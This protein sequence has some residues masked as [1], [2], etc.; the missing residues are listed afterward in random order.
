MARG[1]RSVRS[2]GPKRLVLTGALLLAALFLARFSWHTPITDDAERALYD[3]RSYLFAPKVEQDNR[4]LLVV[5]NDQTLINARKRSPLDRG[6]L[7]RALHNLDAMGAK[8]IGIDILFDQPQDE[9]DALVAQLRSMKTPVSI[10]Y[11]ETHSNAGDIIFEQQKFL[12]SFLARVKGSRAGPAS[13]RLDD[14]FGA[15]RIW[16]AVEPG[17]PL[18]LGR[19]ILNS[20]G[21]GRSVM[22]GY[23]GAIRYRR[24]AHDDRPV[25]TTIPIDQFADPQ[26]AP[27]MAPVV[28]GRYVII[29]GSL[30]DVDRVDTTFTSVDGQTTPG[31]EVHAEMLAQMLDGARLPRPSSVSLWAQALLIVLAAALTGLLEMRSWRFVPLLIAQAVLFA[32]L[33]FWLQSR[34]IDTYLFP[35][36]GPILGWIVAFAAIVAAA[37]A[38]GAVQRRFAHSALGKYLPRNIAQEIIDRPELL[39]LHGEKKEIFVLFSDLEGFTKMSHALEP[40]MVA[41]LLNRYLDTLS[42]IVLEHGGVIDKFVGD[43]VVAFWGAPIALPDDGARAAR[44]GYAIWQA[45]EQ[46]RQSAE[47]GLPPIGRTRVGLHFGE[48]VVGNFGGKTRI[49]YTALG[50]SMNTASRL[51]AAN[52]ELDTRVLASREFVEGSTLDWWRP[53][54]RVVLRGRSK[55]VDVFEAAPDFAEADR[56]ALE[57]AVKLMDTDRAAAIDVIA[58]VWRRNPADMALENLLRRCS[59][60]NEEGAYVLG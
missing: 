32:G 44:A 5:Y 45:G 22:P 34:G 52:K 30:V 26:V 18:L 36:V 59:K 35:A 47:R 10:A 17:L 41:T 49:Q 16:P 15:T 48:A 25:F 42:D 28:A 6:L 2:A 37:R 33:P 1:W 60:L 9:D 29:G 40:E 54:G 21:Q 50:D 43:A 56:R 8:A 24:A 23:A 19:S 7:A 3:L 39:A 38:S 20:A 4:I 55:P 51:E 46:F 27:L 31:I 11:A 58:E 53:M 13:I 57:K 12:E 14:S